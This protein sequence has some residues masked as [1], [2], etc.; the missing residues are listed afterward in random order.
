MKP[1]YLQQALFSLPPTLDATYERMLTG[2]DEMYCTEALVALRWLAFERRPLTLDEIAEACVIDP[3]G[4]GDVDAGNRGGLEDVLEILSGLIT[5]ETSLDD[6][7][8]GLGRSMDQIIDPEDDNKQAV[9]SFEYLGKDSR[10]R[11]AHYSVKEYLVSERIR[12]SKAAQY[13]LQ[14][15]REHRFLAQSCL[16]YL[17]YYSGSNDKV[18]KKQDFTAFPLLEYAARWWFYHSRLQDTDEVAREILLLSLEH[19]RRDWLTVYAPDQLWQRAFHSVLDAGSALYYTSYLGLEDVSRELIAARA[20]VNAQGGRFGNA[21]QAASESGHE[22]TAAMLIEKGAD[23]NAQGGRYGNALQAASLHGHE[24]IVE[25][26]IEKGAD[27]NA[28]GGRYGNALQAA[29]VRGHEKTAE[30]LIEKGADVNAQ[31]GHF[32]NAL[33]AASLDG[34]EKTVAMLIEKGAHAGEALRVA[35]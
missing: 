30:M 26:L 25:M 1:K 13:F 6:D 24:K 23:V 34:H 28:Q 2:I 4:D 7:D 18:L 20:D 14:E 29:S 11:L 32:G 9:P 33:Q 19:C 8:D 27:V 21:L 31:G 35:S 12:R 3:S 17:L 22:N 5:V 15:N 10:V 16:T